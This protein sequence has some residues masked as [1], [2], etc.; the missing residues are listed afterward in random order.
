MPRQIFDLSHEIEDGLITYKGLPA[1]VICD[2]LSRE[3]PAALAAM[4]D[5]GL[6]PPLRLVPTPPTWEQERVAKLRAVP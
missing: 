1:P 5:S 4:A 6:L 3:N 2:F